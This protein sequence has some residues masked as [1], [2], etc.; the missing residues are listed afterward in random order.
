[1]SSSGAEE[2]TEMSEITIAALLII[3]TVWFADFLLIPTL[4]FADSV[5]AVVL[6]DPLVFGIALAL[7]IGTMIAVLEVT[8]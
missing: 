4:E 1:M 6:A 3:G 2:Q 5:L 7:V 8:S